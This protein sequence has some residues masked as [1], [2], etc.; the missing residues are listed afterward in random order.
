MKVYQNRLIVAAL[1]VLFALPIAAFA[2]VPRVH[3]HPG[4]RKSMVAEITP[5]FS[6]P[7]ASLTIDDTKEN[8]A[9]NKNR[10]FEAFTTADASRIF[11]RELKT[12]RIFEIKGL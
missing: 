1:A 2:Q 12:G 3:R 5:G 10:T 4:R 9:L 11:I 8:I 6:M 7:E